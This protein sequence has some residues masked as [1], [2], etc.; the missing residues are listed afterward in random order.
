[1]PAYI[2]KYRVYQN[3]RPKKSLSCQNNESRRG[4]SPRTAAYSFIYSTSYQAQDGTPA[5]GP[6]GQHCL[7]PRSGG[8]ALPE[9]SWKAPL[10]YQQ[11]K[12]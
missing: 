6:K 11:R 2:R 10:L 4:L 3:S 5:A 8:R 7:F 12:H 9:S 1:M